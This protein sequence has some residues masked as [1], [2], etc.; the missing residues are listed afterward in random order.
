MPREVVTSENR[1]EYMEK[2]LKL[3]N[4]PKFSY[5][6]YQIG[7][8][9]RTGT[10]HMKVTEHD[11]KGEGY[12][13]HAVTPHG[14][15]HEPKR[16]MAVMHKDVGTGKHHLYAKH[17][18]YPKNEESPK[19]RAKKMDDEQHER[20]KKH[21]KYEKLKAEVGKRQAINAIL[22][23]LNMGDSEKSLPK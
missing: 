21:P 11:K 15:A 3:D 12:M 2:K 23:E 18:E 19:E 20:A 5:P 4:S 13:G 14:E 6:H 16:E 7:D 1:K 9:V 10:G 22:H 17:G 8:I